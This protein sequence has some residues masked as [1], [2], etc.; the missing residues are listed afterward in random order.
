MTTWEAKNGSYFRSI[1]LQNLLATAFLSLLGPMAKTLSNEFSVVLIDIGAINSTVLLITGFISL[2]W[3][4]LAD[5]SKRTT[6]LLICTG[7]WSMSS[8][9]IPFINT[10]EFL[11]LMQ[12]IAAVGIGGILPIS[13]SLVVDL[14]PM[15]K[16]SYALGLLQTGITLGTG[17]G[18]LLSGIITDFLSWWVPFL[19]IAFLSLINAIF[20]AKVQEPIKGSYDR[21]LNSDDSPTEVIEF[22]LNREVLESIYKVKSNRFIIGSTMIK[23]LSVGAINFYFVSMMIVDHGFSSS[24]ATIL[25][26]IVFSA[27][28]IGS[29]YIGRKTDAY[30][31]KNKQAKVNVLI[32]LLLL[33]GMF[34]LLGF[35]LVF[36]VDDIGLVMLFIGFTYSGAF[37]LSADASIA[38]AILSEVNPPHVRSTIFSLQ[39][40]AT[41]IGQSMGVLMLG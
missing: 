10:Y 13:L 36:K 32:I 6:L 41:S 5:K 33:G 30:S 19:I 9:L 14:T 35:S 29:P 12:V 37:L 8:L 7:I 40:I 3:A 18:L 27:Q 2:L 4:L 22:K 11:F 16:R 23:S 31:L 38:Q 24:I 25:M 21:Y 17:F 39:N 34:Y 1:V 15:E 26:I 28:M 20:L